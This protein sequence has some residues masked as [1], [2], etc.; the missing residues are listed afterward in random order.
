MAQVSY[1]WGGTV[2]GDATEAPYSDDEWSDLWSML[3]TYD[4]TTQGV[5]TSARS[6]YSGN[7]AVTNPS[8]LTLRVA[9][10]IAVVDGK[11]YLNSASV[12]NSI[13]DNTNWNIVVL[14]KDFA[15]QTVRVALKSGYASEAAALAALTQTD[16]TTWEIPLATANGDGAGGVSTLTDQRALL[17]H[18]ADRTRRFFVSAY[19]AYNVTDVADVGRGED[20]Q[21][22]IMPDAKLSQAGATF[23]VPDD[24]LSGLSV[25]AVFV[26]DTWVGTALSIYVKQEF[27][28]GSIGESA[29][30]HSSLGAYAQLLATIG[31][32]IAIPATTLSS[33]TAGDIVNCA[34]YRD[35]TDVNDDTSADAWFV[36][37]L[38][39]YTA[40]S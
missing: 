8:G 36:G 11:V 1:P 23:V 24:Y 2:T 31:E 20:W 40:D 6:G 29:S 34:A 30:V 14:R 3:F 19:T 7:L 37:F 9:T 22:V 39:S 33:V 21:G 17:K 15:T 4:R 35:A 18:T 27:R 5:M 13:P 38:V 10:G 28:Y 25:R 26:S 16:G 12:D 32:L